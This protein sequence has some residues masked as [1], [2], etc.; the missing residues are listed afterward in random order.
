MQPRALT[1]Y[2]CTVSDADSAA[3]EHDP[4]ER[5]QEVRINAHEERD[6]RQRP[7]RNNGDLCAR[8]GLPRLADR[9]SDGLDGGTAIVDARP[10]RIQVRRRETFHAAEPAGAVDLGVGPR[11]SEEGRG[12]AGMHFDVLWGRERVQASRG[13]SRGILDGGVAVRL[14]CK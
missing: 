7:R 8:T 6:V 11:R 4:F 14:A 5:M 2:R 13:V 1:C 9:S 3:H 12:G 10:H